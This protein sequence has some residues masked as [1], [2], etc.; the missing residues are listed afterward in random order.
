VDRG[1]KSGEIMRVDKWERA[2][3][4]ALYGGDW[5]MEHV[6]VL[7]S[8]VGPPPLLYLP[9]KDP[10]TNIPLAPHSLSLSRQSQRVH[11]SF[12]DINYTDVVLYL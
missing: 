5:R 10:A 1:E 6:L 9:G 4:A 12:M 8:S 3:C 7:G 11:R 2:Q